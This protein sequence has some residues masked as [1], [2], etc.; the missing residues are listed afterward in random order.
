MN[1]SAVLCL[2]HKSFTFS[3]R[4]TE[5]IL[6]LPE[7]HEDKNYSECKGGVRRM[8]LTTICIILVPKFL[9]CVVW[10]VDNAVHQIKNHYPEDS[11]VYC[12]HLSSG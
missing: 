1:S 8:L 3:H 4:I 9:P 6:E 11:I 7:E 5:L 10:K 12:Q 2:D